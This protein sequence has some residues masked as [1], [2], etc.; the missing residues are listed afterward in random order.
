MEA[1]S[2]AAK[3]SCVSAYYPPKVES[4]LGFRPFVCYFS[5]FFSSRTD[6]MLG[7]SFFDTFQLLHTALTVKSSFLAA[8]HQGNTKQQEL[9]YVSVVSK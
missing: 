7:F 1:V 3:A 4:E 6:L 9:P 8:C 2:N 5:F